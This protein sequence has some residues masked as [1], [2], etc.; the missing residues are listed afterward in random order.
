MKKII[1]LFVIIILAN[2]LDFFHALPP[3]LHWV[4]K[5]TTLI[6]LGYLFYKA[7]ITRV[8]F[9][10]SH[11]GVN[12]S[13]ILSS[14]ILVS[15]VL[16]FSFPAAGSEFIKLL[17]RSLKM[18]L[19]LVSVFSLAFGGLL[20]LVIAIYITNLITFKKRS[21]MG[22]IKETGKPPKHFSK[23]ALRTLYTFILLLAFYYFIFRIFIEWFALAV[24]ATFLIILLF[25][26]LIL[27]LIYHKHFKTKTMLQ[28][29]SSAGESYYEKFVELFHTKKTALF[30]ISGLLVL[31]PLVDIANFIIPYLTGLY[32]EIYLLRLPEEGHQ[33]IST[34]L[35]VDSAQFGALASWMYFFNLIAI[36]CFLALPS[37]IWF[38]IFHKQKI[39][40][41]K[42]FL[43][44]FAIALPVY[45]LA[46][47]FSL[48]T[49]GQI[50]Y[51]TLLG[52]DITTHTMQPLINLTHVFIISL[53]A[54]ILTVALYK[55]YRKQLNFIVVFS[56]L[57]FLAYYVIL[58]FMDTWSHL[59]ISFY[60]M[61]LRP[62]LVLISEI[63]AI[64]ILVFLILSILFY[65]LAFYVYLTEIRQSFR[66]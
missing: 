20:F 2:I 39:N 11:H 1:Y 6:L 51:V 30:A 15:N 43:T 14:F 63:A 62:G 12:I 21:F 60:Y 58:F 44:S 7:D 41:P 61:W 19:P 8:F 47:I 33:L 3:S 55:K 23:F 50:P 49:L 53:V 34:L 42:P 56:S 64:L 13:I 59:G 31:H 22:A 38:R 25:I 24:H 40:F 4:E 35:T 29:I 66:K 9:G 54:G 57:I 32:N 17:M 10:E 52:V 46:P 5:L 26:F 37:L 16:I 27:I 65:P 28:E 36:L 48:R 45:L 18:N